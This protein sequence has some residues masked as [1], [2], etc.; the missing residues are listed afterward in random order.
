MK[1]FWQPIALRDIN[2]DIIFKAVDWYSQLLQ[3]PG[4]I[5]EHVYLIFELFCTVRTD[6]VLQC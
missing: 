3:T 4:S 2:D 5:K 1:S 6:V